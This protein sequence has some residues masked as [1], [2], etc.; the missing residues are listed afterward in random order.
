MSFDQ[1]AVRVSNV[2]KR[3]EIYSAP[4]DR[5][6]QFVLPRIQSR[7]QEGLRRQ[8]FNEFWALRDVSFEIKRGETIGVIGRNGSGKSTLLQ[9][10][11]GTLT[12]SGGTIETRGRVAALL[13][14]G[15]GFNPEFTGRDNVYMNAA[16]LGLTKE[17]INSKFPDIES[18]ADIGHFLDQPVKTYSSGMMARLAFSVAVQVE[19]DILVVDEALSVGDMAFQEKSFT[20][21]KK[22]RDAGTSILFVS[23]STSAVRNFCDRAIWL[24]KGRIRAIGE[25]QGV[26][27]RYQAEMEQEIRKE[28]ADSIP[29]TG[30]RQTTSN[31]TLKTK[32]IA[33]LSVSANKQRYKMG[34]DIY[35][36]ISLQCSGVPP[37]YGVGLIVY[38]SN[39]KV[40]TIINSLRED[41][42]FSQAKPSLTLVV[43]NNNFV[44]GA[45]RA[46]LSV[47]DEHGMFSYDKL[48]SCFQFAIEMERSARGLAKAE[49]ALRSDHEWIDNVG[50]EQ[51]S[52]E[53]L[54][55]RPG[56]PSKSA[57]KVPLLVLLRVRNEALILQD[58][59]DHLST[60]ADYIC[61]YDD[62]STD[63]TRE[64]LK[65]CEK[66]VLVLENYRW[67]PG[68]DD[69][70]LSETRHRGL[71]LEMARR[72]FEFQWCMCCDADE[73]YI[74]P[75]REYVTAAL[76]N[77]PEAVR[78]QLFDA[79]MSPGDDASYRL[80]TPL[81]NFRRFFGVE[82]RDILM[83]WQNRD[84]VRF[85]GLDAREPTVSGRVDVN[86]FC[87]HYG[88]SLSYEHWEATCDYY[89]AYFPWVPYGEKWSRRKGQALHERSDFGR[90]LQEW[91]GAL[92]E[93][94]IKIN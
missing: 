73:R 40:V 76:D 39:E 6:K 30:E 31:S 88:K 85:V 69:R 8:Y 45:Y 47:S 9:M 94:S 90:A 27:D 21:M 93:N 54:W 58:T 28:S 46:A 57:C 51:N 3:Y 23:H 63:T 24:D 4:I 82:R 60:F 71:L 75:I 56:L 33:I 41:L 61:V 74:G 37:V 50:W 15:S 49:G 12:P 48:E 55:V 35:I 67:Q 79:Y 44:P 81:L 17:E 10:I 87:Q 68:V 92:F 64:L 66:V 42:F 70:L 77:K 78:I 62:A 7:L 29:A 32:T 19:P 16:I 18:F 43:K 65:S 5:L 1:I 38:D 59:L 84:S 80:G 53:C 72:Y 13:E 26:C 11:C 89:S 34:D 83:L 25:R 86:F 20:R 91:S 36:D 2:D 52:D 22:I 14:L